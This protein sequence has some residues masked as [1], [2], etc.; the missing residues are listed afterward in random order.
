MRRKVGKAREREKEK[1][2]WKMI[3]KHKN[4]NPT[5]ISH[6]CY[7]NSALEPGIFE[8]RAYTYK[9]CKNAGDTIYYS[10]L[11]TTLFL[12]CSRIFMQSIQFYSWSVCVCCITVSFLFFGIMHF[13]NSNNREMYTWITLAVCN[14]YRSIKINSFAMPKYRFQHIRFVIIHSILN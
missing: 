10:S 12:F 2:S 7:I 13:A 4:E 8:P 6:I 11:F 9:Q 14:A 1:S 5:I 3:N